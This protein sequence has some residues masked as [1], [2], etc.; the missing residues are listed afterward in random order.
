M[1]INQ[2][3]NQVGSRQQLFDTPAGHRP[4]RPTKRRA[5]C[6]LCAIT[7]AVAHGVFVDSAHTAANFGKLRIVTS[8]GHTDVQQMKGAG[9]LEGYLTAGVWCH[10]RLVV[11]P[12]VYVESRLLCVAT[13]CGGSNIDVLPADSTPC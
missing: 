11:G 7:G 2:G 9:W 4:L 1:C 13:P 3:C 6:V 5:V 8:A 10:Q 12:R